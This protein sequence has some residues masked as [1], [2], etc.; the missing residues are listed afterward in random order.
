MD[1]NLAHRHMT[2][3][4]R[5]DL[6]IIG[7]MNRVGIERDQGDD[8]MIFF[9]QTLLPILRVFSKYFNN[10]LLFIT[11]YYTILLRWLQLLL[12]GFLYTI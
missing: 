6:G 3:R 4:G 8:F 1:I 10:A 7:H 5:K 11:W 9:N 2:G 12:L